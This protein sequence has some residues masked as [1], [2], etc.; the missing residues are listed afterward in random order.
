MPLDPTG[1]AAVC[2]LASAVL[3]V[4]I[5]KGA[6]LL[7]QRKKSKAATAQTTQKSEWDTVKEHYMRL[8]KEVDRLFDEVVELRKEN[9]KLRADLDAEQAKSARLQRRVTQLENPSGE[10]PLKALT[11]T[12][13]IQVGTATLVEEHPKAL[14]PAPPPLAPW[15][16][17]IE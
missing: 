14:E 7:Q 9:S 12:N 10:R 8:Q 1:F 5:S 16:E 11:A 13:P 6:D 17:P 3:V 15:E 2:S 4:G